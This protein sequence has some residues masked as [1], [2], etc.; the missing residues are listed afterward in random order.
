MASRRQRQL[1]RKYNS[2]R[3]YTAQEDVSYLT[4]SSRSAYRSESVTSTSSAQGRNSS[5][6]IVTG[7]ETRSYPVYIAIQNFTPDGT[8]TEAVTLEQGQIVEVLEKSNP[9]A[10]LVR[11]K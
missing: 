2:Y 10:W 5:T 3:R 11:T 1:Q 6:E 7:S 9:T 8:E 4:H